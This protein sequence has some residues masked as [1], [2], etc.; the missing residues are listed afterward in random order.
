MEA[1]DAPQTPPPSV[2]HHRRHRVL[3]TVLLAVAFVTGLLAMF[4]VWVNRQAL[5]TDNWTQTSS[6]LLADPEIQNALGAYVV[7]ELFRNVDVAGELRQVLPEQATGLAGPAAAGLRQLG[8]RVAPQ[9]LARPRVQQAWRRSNRAAHEQLLRVI[10]GGGPAVSTQGGNVVLNVR[11]LVDQLAASVGVEEQVSAAREKLQGGAG[12]AA[13]GV[14]QQRLGV[15]LPESTGKI[16]VL[17]S[18]QLESAQNVA[19]AIKG[20]AIVLTVVSLGLFAVAVWLAEG[21]RRVALRTTG[22]CFVGLGLV[23]LFGRR[24]GGNRLVDDLVASE[25][26]RPAAHSA[27]MIGTSLLYDIAVAMLVYGLIFVASAWLAG[28]TRPAVATRRALAPSLRDRLGTVYGVVAVLFLLV[29][30]WGPTPATRQLWGILLLAALIVLGIEVLRRQTAREFPD[31]QAGETLRGL[32]ERARTLR[33]PRRAA[34]PGA[35][36]VAV[37]ELERLVALHDRGALDDD[38]FRVQKELLLHGS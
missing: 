18:K 25:S 14:A 34:A 10:E 9:V 4:A 11:P 16:V 3:V 32:R 7:D 28:S 6:E 33:R 17:R 22:W 20:L 38:E 1:A 2:A 31:A 12:D 35:R 27:W 37:D 24:V 8:T 15:T 30:L 13:R 36:P 19:E 23:V 29:L 5:N 21:W 26:V